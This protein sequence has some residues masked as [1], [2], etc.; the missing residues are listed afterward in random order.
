MKSLPNKFRYTFIC[1]IIFV[2]L[3]GS[4]SVY[5]EA[6]SIKRDVDSY[7]GPTNDSSPASSNFTSNNYLR[8][9]QLSINPLLI[10]NTF[11]GSNAYDEGS[12]IVVD[13]S[14]NIYITGYSD[15]SWGNPIRPFSTTPD[16]F[17]AKLDPSGNL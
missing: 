4:E 1:S 17:V 5:A 9:L 13:S 12:D 6:V 3:A 16:A 15:V 8:A 11:L 2:A 10:W 14:G 7:H